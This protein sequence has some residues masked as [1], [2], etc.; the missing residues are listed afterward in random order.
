MR[1]DELLHGFCGL[2]GDFLDGVGDAVVAVLPM[3]AGHG[4]EM[5][6][7]VRSEVRVRKRLLG[8]FVP[9]NVDVGNGFVQHAGILRGDTVYVLR[10]GAGQLDDAA[11]MRLRVDQERGNDPGD[12]VGQRSVRCGRSRTGAGSCRWWRWSALPTS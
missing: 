1:C 2:A 4:G 12:V 6:F 3:E 7:D 9:R 10:S 11:E 5:L 8:P